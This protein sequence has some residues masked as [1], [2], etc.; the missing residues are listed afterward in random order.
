MLIS[1]S[2]GVGGQKQLPSF[3]EVVFLQDNVIL[4]NYV[5]S[6]LTYFSP[7]LHG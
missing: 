6:S 3:L 2:L 5:F 1:W 4:K 7:E